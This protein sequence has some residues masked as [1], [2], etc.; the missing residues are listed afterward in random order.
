MLILHAPRLTSTG[1]WSLDRVYFRAGKSIPLAA[2]WPSAEAPRIPV[3]VECTLSPRAT[4]GVCPYKGELLYILW[5]YQ[6]QEWIEV[7]RCFSLDAE[8]WVTLH[9]II[10]R[11]LARSGAEPKPVDVRAMT[12][13]AAEY[14]DAQLADLTAAERAAMLIR[15]HDLLAGRIVAQNVSFHARARKPSTDVRVYN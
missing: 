6:D 12:Q 11:E 3:L 10:V 1:P 14:L 5:R 15:L 2:L 13:R 9:P 4:A 7:A 8:W